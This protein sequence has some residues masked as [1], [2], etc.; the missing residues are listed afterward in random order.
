MR[1]KIYK[2]VSIAMAVLVLAVFGYYLF[3]LNQ[4]TVQTEKVGEFVISDTVTADGIFIRSEFTVSYDGS[5]FVVYEADNGKKIE[6]GGLLASVYT[7]E[8][9]VSK[10]IGADIIEGKLDILNRAIGSA[11]YDSKELSDIEDRLYEL[12]VELAAISATGN[13][14]E[15]TAITEEINYLLCRKQMIIA[16]DEERIAAKEALTKELEFRGEALP[17]STISADTSGYFVFYADGYEG[18]LN[19]SILAELTPEYIE[20]VMT[21]SPAV[22]NK[23]IGRIVTDYKWYFAAILKDESLEGVEEG[24]SLDV[25]FLFLGSKGLE[26]KVENI[27]RGNNGMSTVILSSTAVNEEFLSLR[28]QTAAITKTTVRGI[29]IDIR[30]VR[31]L[32]GQ[33][34]VYAV[35]DGTLEFL[36]IDVIH[37]SEDFYVVKWNDSNDKTVMLYDEIVIGG[38][39]LEE[40]KLIN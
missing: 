36:P 13:A 8:R 28:E 35:R 32:D 15:M 29:K 17:T 22:S 10:R 19:P 7:Y 20:S 2:A 5:G 27:I 39:G 37:T 6:N 21:H 40:G 30:A 38:H 25:S 12:Y 26:M 4:N 23:W 14:Y 11:Q 9:D 34:G 33:I 18:I 1:A 24:K 3:S 31:F 16:T